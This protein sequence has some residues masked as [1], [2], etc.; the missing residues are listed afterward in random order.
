MLFKVVNGQLESYSATDFKHSWIYQDIGSMVFYLACT[1]IYHLITA[2][3]KISYRK[4]FKHV[5]SYNLLK[6]IMELIVHLG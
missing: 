4:Y 1:C 2:S 3:H 6:L 5:S